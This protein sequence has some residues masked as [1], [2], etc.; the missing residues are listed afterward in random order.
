MNLSE[1]I[2]SIMTNRVITLGPEDSMKKV[3]DIFQREKIHHLP[4]IDEGLLVGMISKSDYLFFKRGFHDDRQNNKID[5]FRLKTR[6][7]KDVMTKGLAKMSPDE[8]IDIAIEVFKENLFHAVLIVDD[9]ILRGIIT[10]LDIIKYLVKN[11]G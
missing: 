11:N 1:P 9:G 2:S 7:V 8:S 3:E 5:L 4:V 6:K 10:P